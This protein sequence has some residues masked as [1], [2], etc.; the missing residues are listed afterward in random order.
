MKAVLVPVDREPV[1]VDIPD[2]YEA[3]REAVG[4]FIEYVSTIPGINI[5][6]N[7]EGIYTCK[8]NRIMYATRSMYETGYLSALDG[9]KSISRPGEAYTLLFGDFI[10]VGAG[11]DDEGEE[12]NTGLT[13]EQAEWVKDWFRPR[14]FYLV[15]PEEKGGR[16]GIIISQERYDMAPDKFDIPTK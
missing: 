12:C 11:T 10:I 6:V 9:Y 3:L 2:T 13:E 14:G 4:G 5:V 1:E 15:P 8:P 7:E 16:P